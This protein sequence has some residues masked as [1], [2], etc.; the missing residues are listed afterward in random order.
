MPA[1]PHLGTLSPKTRRISIA[2]ITVAGTAAVAVSLIPGQASAAP[3]SA[4]HTPARVAV[5]TD[6]PTA[7]S[8][9]AHS[10]MEPDTATILSH[11]IA[12]YTVR[13][14]AVFTLTGIPKEG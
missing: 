9:D 12:K 3:A 7:F 14:G 13:P 2:G 8:T 4:A 10:E 11:G 5:Q 6:A 1:S